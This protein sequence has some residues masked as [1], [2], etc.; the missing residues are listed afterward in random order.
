[1]RQALRVHLGELDMEKVELF[2]RRQFPF[3]EFADLRHGHIS[4][5]Q[6]RPVIG[7]SVFNSYFKFAFVRNPFDRFVSYC[8]FR[9]RQTGN[10][11]AAPREFMKFILTDVQ[12][13]E[14]IL[15]RPQ[16]EFVTDASGQISLDFIGRSEQLQ[17]DFDRVCALLGLPG[18]ALARV[19]ASSHGD[20]RQYYDEELIALVSEFYRADLDLF[21]Y[22]FE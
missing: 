11:A 15:F 22:S 5:Q 16:S 1:M 7:E 13:I 19:N 8:A 21:G 9:S 6:I 17:V 20:Y 14:H 12:P 18:S 3:P 4:A 10:F 2:G